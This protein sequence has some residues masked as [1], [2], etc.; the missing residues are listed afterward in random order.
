MSSS[1]PPGDSPDVY[2]IPSV[3]QIRYFIMKAHGATIDQLWNFFDD[4]GS[5]HDED[6]AAEEYARRVDSTAAWMA[7][8]ERFMRRQIPFEWKDHDR[9]P[10]SK[11]FREKMEAAK[12][13]EVEATT[14]AEDGP[15]EFAD[16][17]G[18]GEG[19][20]VKMAH[21]VRERLR[22]IGEGP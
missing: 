8:K 18:E 6:W 5:Y 2:R 17:D 9:E 11:E 13:Q 12:S 7:S 14:E 22:N 1:P 3:A 15:D 19:Q 4:Q 10:R 20:D 16:E 21:L